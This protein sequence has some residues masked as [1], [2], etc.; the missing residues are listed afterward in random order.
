MVVVRK[1]INGA[2]GQLG[3]L[4]IL[5]PVAGS[6][7]R[8]TIYPAITAIVTAEQVTALQGRYQGL[9]VGKVGGNEDGTAT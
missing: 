5:K 4:H 8:F 3:D 7:D 2:I 1:R 6:A 9:A